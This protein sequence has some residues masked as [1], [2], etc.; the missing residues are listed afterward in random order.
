[1]HKEGDEIHVD[2]TEASGGSKQGVMIWVLVIGTFLA[3]AALTII[4]TT[5]ALTQGESEEEISVSNQMAQE[6]ADDA[7]DS[8]VSDGAD[9]IKGAAD[10]TVDGSAV[11]TIENEN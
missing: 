10:Q 1:M 6:E 2:E 11:D 5:G 9:D 4:W 8:I 7:T 3:I